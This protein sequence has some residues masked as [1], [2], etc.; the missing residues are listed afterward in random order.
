ML[1]IRRVKHL[2]ARLGFETLRLQ[3][4]AAT[5]GAFCEELILLDPR[6][7]DRQR[8]VLD[9]R[10]DLRKAQDRLLRRVLMPKLSPS[11]YGHGGVRGRHIKSNIAPHLDSV[12]AFTADISDFYPT[13]SHNRVYRLFVEAFGCTPDVARIC[14]QLCTYRHHLALGLVTS[15]FLAEQ[16]AIPIDRRIAAACHAAGLQFTRYVDDIAISGRY[17]LEHSGFEFLLQKILGEHGFK[18]HPEKR[19][20]G[21]LSAGTPITKITVR[22]GHPDVRR[23]YLAELERQLDDA[24]NL[25]AGG[26]FTGPYYTRGQIAGRVQFVGWVNPGRKVALLARYRHIAW[27]RAAK[28]A[29]LRGFVATK[30]RAVKIG[31]AVPSP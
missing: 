17:D 18:M 19:V 3:E 27:K 30:K 5:V 21:R 20:F 28:E 23:E 11:P 31:E 13:I 16:I 24:N 2:A 29:A 9:V 4:I 1:N 26:E 15:P 25:A 10:G 6:E 22:R 12:F 7:P 14:T 8:P